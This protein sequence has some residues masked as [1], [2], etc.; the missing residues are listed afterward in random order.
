MMEGGGGIA[1]HGDLTTGN[2]ID[3]ASLVLYRTRHQLI[4]DFD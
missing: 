4:R 3:L 2:V 1:C